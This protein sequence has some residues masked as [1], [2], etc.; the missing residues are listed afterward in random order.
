MQLRV[1]ML[2]GEELLRT[3]T[4]GSLMLGS[5]PL[6]EEKEM[7]GGQVPLAEAASC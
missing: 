1:Y 6:A 4:R 7:G 2:G 3:I 5:A